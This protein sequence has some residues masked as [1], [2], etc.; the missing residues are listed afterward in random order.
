MRLKHSFGG[1]ID[2]RISVR[3]TH[4]E[5]WRDHTAAYQLLQEQCAKRLRGVTIR[6]SGCED[7]V[8]GAPD[9]LEN[10]LEAVFGDRLIDQRTQ[11]LSLSP[12]K[13]DY[14]LLAVDA[15]G[16]KRSGQGVGLGA[17]G[18]GQE[19]NPRLVV[20]QA[21][22]PHNLTIAGQRRNRESVCHGLAE[23]GQMGN[24]AVELLCAS[25]VPAEA[26]DHLVEN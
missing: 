23:S 13:F 21:A 20:V 12:E 1:P 2:V 5:G 8:A 18:C 6:V 11:P 22:E 9:Q 26:S 17:M 16:F 25:Q 24:D 4:H 19:E 3:E 14:V 7:Q 10:T 15:H